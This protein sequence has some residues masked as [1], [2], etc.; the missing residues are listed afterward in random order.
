[1]LEVDASV[2]VRDFSF[3]IEFLISSRRTNNKMRNLRQN[4][5]NKFDGRFF[6]FNRKT[7]FSHFCCDFLQLSVALLV[8]SREN[9][10]FNFERLMFDL[11]S[12]HFVSRNPPQKE[13]K[14][15]LFI[16]WFQFE[17]FV[18]VFLFEFSFCCSSAWPIEIC[19]STFLPFG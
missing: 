10:I 4:Q 9:S 14:K 17:L 16:L 12:F 1:M 8:H 6:C 15:K 19:G 5:T 2:C 11:S 13:R 3:K 18:A 7:I